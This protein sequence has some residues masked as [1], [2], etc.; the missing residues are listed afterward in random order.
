M[1][2][3]KTLCKSSAAKAR[4]TGMGFRRGVDVEAPSQHLLF[5]R[6]SGQIATELA[7]FLLNTRTPVA[8]YTL[9]LPLG[10]GQTFAKVFS[11]FGAGAGGANTK[12]WGAGG[13][14]GATSEF[15]GRLGSHPTSLAGNNSLICGTVTRARGRPLGGPEGE[16]E[17]SAS[18][19][20]AGT[21]PSPQ[22]SA[23]PQAEP[24]GAEPCLGEGVTV[25]L[26]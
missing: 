19:S 14:F 3:Q 8:S 17:A 18:G 9:P 1:Q 4:S 22:P 25:T 16:A 20:V 15:Y 13:R 21:P 23:V 5:H 2:K 10:A 6:G 24:V 7:P 12:S 11:K 26:L